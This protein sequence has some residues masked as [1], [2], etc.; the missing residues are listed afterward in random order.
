MHVKV[1]D[2]NLSQLEDMMDTLEFLL[3]RL[4]NNNVGLMRFYWEP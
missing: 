2:T 1:P 3:S 4:T